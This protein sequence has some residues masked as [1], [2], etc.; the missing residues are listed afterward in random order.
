MNAIQ[1]I[2][3]EIGPPVGAAY[4]KGWQ[5]ALAAFKA[6]DFNPGDVIPMAWFFEHFRVKPPEARKTMAEFQG[7]QFKFMGEMD[8]FQAALAEDLSLVLQNVKGEGYRVVP[9][10]EQTEWAMDKVHRD[11]SKAMSKAH[12]RLTHLRLSELSDDQRRQNADAQAKLAALRAG[13][14]KALE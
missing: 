9:P 3:Q 11:F 8:R 4:D 12:M 1:H 6:A 5:N 10:A 13:G 14:R 7:E 2:H